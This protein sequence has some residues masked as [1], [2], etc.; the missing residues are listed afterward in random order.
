[1]WRGK[2]HNICDEWQVVS[3]W[4]IDLGFKIQLSCFIFSLVK[5][6]IFYTEDKGSIQNFKTT[7]GLNS[8]IWWKMDQ[9]SQPW[10]ESPISDCLVT[11]PD[12]THLWSLP[13]SSRS[14]PQTDH[15][16]EEDQETDFPT[17]WM[18]TYTTLDSRPH[19]PGTRP[20]IG[21]D[22]CV[23]RVLEKLC[24][25]VHPFCSLVHSSSIAYLPFTNDVPFVKDNLIKLKSIANFM[26]GFGVFSHWG[27]ACEYI[28]CLS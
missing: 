13:S 22:G 9:L 26:V 4:K 1:L 3:S 24:F 10:S 11:W 17:S 20:R 18:T 14:N 25:V 6:V 12:Q 19:Q 27:K 28:Y 5:M 21:Q 16:Q 15:A 8:I 2:T 23:I 7:Q